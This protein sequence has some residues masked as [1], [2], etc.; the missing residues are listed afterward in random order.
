MKDIEQP[1]KGNEPPASAKP[2]RKPVRGVLVVACITLVT[3]ILIAVAIYAGAFLILA[4]I[5]Q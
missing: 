1:T 2:K 5:M 4:P 3:L